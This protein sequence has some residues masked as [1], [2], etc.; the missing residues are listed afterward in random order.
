MDWMCLAGSSG[1]EAHEACVQIRPLAFH[2]FYG[3]LSGGGGSSL[4]DR[5]NNSWPSQGCPQGS[6]QHLDVEPRV[7]E[8][9]LW[10]WL[11][12]GGPAVPDTSRIVMPPLQD[13]T[14]IPLPG[15]DPVAFRPRRW[16]CWKHCFTGQEAA[17]QIAAAFLRTH[18]DALARRALMLIDAIIQ[19]ETARVV[20]AGVICVDC[21]VEG[22]DIWYT[23]QTW[24]ETLCEA[25]YET[26]VAHG[27]A[28]PPN[29]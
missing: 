5:C 6:D 12:L 26:R 2:Y 14:P 9:L 17:H 24:G 21:G 23:G 25:C 19:Q 10:L 27:Q 13:T 1:V 16:P 20:E 18:A 11:W 8:A 28:Q 4:R 7:Q 29:P 15:A 22:L 3:A